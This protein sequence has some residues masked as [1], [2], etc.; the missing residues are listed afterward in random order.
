MKKTTL[1]AVMALLCLNFGLYAQT[2]IPE[3]KVGDIVPKSF[4]QAKHNFLSKDGNK[5]EVTMNTYK[6]RDLLIDFWA[7]WCGAFYLL[8]PKTLVTLQ[9]EYLN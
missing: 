7:C 8:I 5:Q 6:G 2:S 1:L 3:L 9:S 4:W